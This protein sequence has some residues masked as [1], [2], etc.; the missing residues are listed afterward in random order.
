MV[1]TRVITESF[2]L[3]PAGTSN[4]QGYG[5]YSTWFNPTGQLGM[6]IINGRF[7]GSRA[8]QIVNTNGGYRVFQ[9][10]DTLVLGMAMKWNS[11]LLPV[12]GVQLVDL[13]S[14]GANKQ[15]SLGANDTGQIQLWRGDTLV[16]T[17]GEPRL[18]QGAWHYIELEL[19]VHDSSGTARVYIDGVEDETLA[20][21]GD[22]KGHTDLT[23]GRCYLWSTSGC[24]IQYDDF[25]LEI[26]GNVRVGEGRMQALAPKS[27]I[28]TT[29]FTP[30][31][32]AT[33]HKCV[34][35]L[36]ANITD[37]ISA[38]PAGSVFRLGL[39][40]LSTTPETIYGVQVE[41]LSQK[42]EAG[43]RT[44]RNK[45][46][47]LTETVDGIEHACQLNTFTFKR[48]W[49]PTEPDANEEWSFSTVNSLDIGGE[50]VV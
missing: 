20:F 10:T 16:A 49:F 45:I 8:M 23:I 22:T 28:S 27:T 9:D 6:S 39:D 50:L 40:N 34:D 26:D 31:T 18:I 7:T 13:R 37:Y 14:V 17:S 47:G 1:Q 43:T 48:D 38:L 46:F 33:L 15:F 24:T 36:P 44:I 41:S 3:Y 30:S 42:N 2:D 21:D 5:L 29:G 4:E 35:E 12:A 19:F 32:G 11:G 25:Y